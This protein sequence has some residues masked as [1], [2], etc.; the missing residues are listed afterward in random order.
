MAQDLALFA[1]P[2]TLGFLIDRC[3]GFVAAKPAATVRRPHLVCHRRDLQDIVI[4][5]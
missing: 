5:N 1:R 2:S 3:L 4:A